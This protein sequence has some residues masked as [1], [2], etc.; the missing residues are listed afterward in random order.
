M[1]KGTD[2][3]EETERRDIQETKGKRQ[4]RTDKKGETERR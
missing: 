3:G 4:K 1:Q 2:R